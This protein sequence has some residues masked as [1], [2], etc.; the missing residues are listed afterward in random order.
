MKV[1][2]TLLL[3]AVAIGFFAY[4]WLVERKREPAEKT[5]ER[6]EKVFPDFKEEEVESLEVINSTGTFAFV[7]EDKAWKLVKPIAADADSGI[8]GGVLSELN[9][10]R[11]TTAIEPAPGKSLVAADFGLDAPQ[12]SIAFRQKGQPVR[13]LLVGK[14]DVT[15]DNVYVRVEGQPDILVVSQYL[16]SRVDKPLNEFRDKKVV[17]LDKEKVDKVEIAGAGKVPV[18]LVKEGDRWTITAPAPDFADAQ[19]VTDLLGALQD[20][21]AEEFA[22]GPAAETLEKRGLKAPSLQV[23]AWVKDAAKQILVGGAVPDQKERLYALRGGG[24]TVVVVAKGNV[25]KLD[26]GVADLRARKILPCKG[27]DVQKMEIAKGASRIV[28]EKTGE[29]WKMT[30]PE[31]VDVEKDAVKGLFDALIALDA[32]ETAEEAPSTAA[33][34]KFGLAAPAVTLTLTVRDVKEPLEISLGRPDSSGKYVYLRRSRSAPVFAVSFEFLRTAAQDA[35]AYRNRSVVKADK[36]LALKLRVEREDGKF[37]LSRPD[38]KRDDL[39]EMVEPVAATAGNDAIQGILGEFADLRVKRYVAEGIG[40]LKKYG[41]DKPALTATLTLKGAKEGESKTEKLLLGG[42]DGDDVFGL[43]EGKPLVFTLTGAQA[44]K[45]RE[46]LRSRVIFSFSDKDAR[47]LR[48]AAGPD[49]IVIVKEGMDWRMTKP[50][51]ALA[52]VEAVKDYLNIVSDLQCRA[53]AAHKVAEKDLK[54]FGLDAPRLVIAVDVAGIPRKLSIG[55]KTAGG[56]VYART[57]ELPAVFLLPGDVAARL[58]KKA[59]DFLPPVPAA[60]EKPAETPVKADAAV[61]APPEKPEAAKPAP[62]ETKPKPSG[63]SSR[64]R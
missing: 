24:D 5:K 21:R 17:A 13:K 27:D 10:M 23:T 19:K 35:L 28:F 26:K 47:S 9:Y 16:V 50:R 18:T 42:K 34:A 40:E 52:K 51:D 38:E 7:R 49:E 41:L 8:V 55:G 45:F 31:G 32:A 30:K 64:R 46:E 11:R 61:P 43:V 62:T 2:N 44:A 6:N 4:V 39:W 53:F 22:E 36:T 15:N 3:L 33:L 57:N 48:L 59:D 20:L 58:L 54:G 14:K 25:E 63:P 60:G 37:L 12:T 29:D 56:D 1:R